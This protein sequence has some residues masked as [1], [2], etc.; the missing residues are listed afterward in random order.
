MS[1]IQLVPYDSKYDQDLA[2]FTIAKAESAFAL[3][4]F[5]ALEDLASGE[6]PV[7]V[8][9]QQRPVGFLRLNQ[10]DECAD[11]AQN[12]NAILVKSFSITERMQGQGIA[13]AALAQLPNYVH[14]H[15]PHTNEIILSVN[16]QNPKA[17]HVYQKMGYID[18]QRVLEG[19]AGP[20]HVMSY[21][22]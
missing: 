4:P 16:F 19:P 1:D 15:F 8:L 9:H 18:T 2:Q 6:Y 10:N 7:V 3:L 11:L 14:T 13:Q 5:A 12:A 17:I 20:Q 22:I 21:P